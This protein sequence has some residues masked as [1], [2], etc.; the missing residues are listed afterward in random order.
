MGQILGFYESQK[1][2]F[3]NFHN[4]RNVKSTANSKGTVI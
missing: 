3:M 2:N 4:F 1:W